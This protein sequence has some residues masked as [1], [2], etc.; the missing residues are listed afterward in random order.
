MD[1]FDVKENE[2]HGEDTVFG[3]DKKGPI[4]NL[5][6]D[7]M[8]H[9][10]DAFGTDHHNPVVVN[11]FSV[12]SSFFSLLL[13]QAEDSHGKDKFDVA[14]PHPG[15]TADVFDVGHM[16]GIS[17]D[18]DKYPSASKYENEQDQEPSTH[19]S[20]E[21]VLPQPIG[22]DGT[23]N[24]QLNP[25]HQGGDEAS[26]PGIAPPSL[27]SPDEPITPS[28]TEETHDN[29]AAGQPFSLSSISPSFFCSQMWKTKLPAKKSSN[30]P[31][32]RPSTHLPL[33]YR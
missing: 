11:L 8:V 5:F 21:T 7:E 20:E 28:S 18:V 27:L 31:N 24:F 22:P 13:Y 1:A 3:V 12:S 4:T 19:Q 2:H 32:P 23:L 29:A 15:P 16:T 17:S 10:Q 6:S 25:R 9:S 30:S 14:P 33:R 26:P